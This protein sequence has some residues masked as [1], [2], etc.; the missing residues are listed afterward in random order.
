[1]KKRIITSSI[2]ILLLVASTSGFLTKSDSNSSIRE[3]SISAYLVSTPILIQNDADFYNYPEITGDGSQLTPFVIQNLNITNPGGYGINISDVT[4]YWEIKDCYIKAD[5]PIIL[6]FIFNKSSIINNTIE[7]DYFGGNGIT[8]DNTGAGLIIQK[9]YFQECIYGI[10]VEDS[11]NFLIDGNHFYENY[12]SIFGGHLTSSIIENN[13]F[14]KHQEMEFAS[15]SELDFFGNTFKDSSYGLKLG[16]VD[17]V[18]ITD[19]IFID[20]Y[21]YGVD[22]QSG[23]DAFIYSN[24]FIRNG[25]FYISQAFCESFTVDIEWYYGSIGNFWSD[26][27]DGIVYAIDGNDELL[28]LY[29]FYNSDSDSLNDYE[30]V[31]IHLTDR[32]DEDT[33]SDK[34]P[35]DYEVENLLDP[36]VDDSLDDPDADLLINILEYY[37]KTD[38]QQWDSDSDLLPDGYEAFNGLN[39]LI[40]DSGK[41]LDGD[42]LTNWQ[43]YSLGT[44]PNKVDSDSDG[45]DDFWENDN[46]LDPLT[47]DA[48]ADPDE[49]YLNNFLEYIYD[50][51]P[52]SNDTDGDSHIDSWEVAHGTNPNDALDFPDE[53]MS[54]PT[55]ESPI[56]LTYVIISL[57]AFAGLF[58]FKRR[59]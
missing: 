43:E 11:S 15:C 40:P 13:I 8:V 53:I 4:A 56:S 54:T 34:M 48:Y 16:S 1:M 57:L 45:M 36:L 6:D 49:D 22:Y 39:P 46:G 3:S 58:V 24:Y 59:R 42:G 28:D 37:E 19:N 47:N 9:N 44:M 25:V 35:D 7:T 52:F 41:D 5:D 55:E 31:K 2:L 29:P 38:P 30:E 14:E 20:N 17:F 12:Y 23:S 27:G 21:G 51:N 32:F 10:Y 50:C 18:N 33:D 26:L